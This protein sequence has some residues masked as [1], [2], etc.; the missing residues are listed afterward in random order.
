MSY[1]KKLGYD[2]NNYH[3]TLDNFRR[4]IS[5]P[6]FYDLTDEQIHTVVRAV[7]E[8]IDKVC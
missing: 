5:L 2:L 6:V 7:K 1:Y 8:A 3:T 4:E